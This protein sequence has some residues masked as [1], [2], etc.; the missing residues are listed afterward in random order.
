MLVS[1][2]LMLNPQEKYSGKCSNTY[3][4]VLKM[5]LSP[6]PHLIPHLETDRQN[7]RSGH[8]HFIHSSHKKMIHSYNRTLFRTLK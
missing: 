6:D 8:R 2:K 4:K 7:M 3:L 5:S 1:E